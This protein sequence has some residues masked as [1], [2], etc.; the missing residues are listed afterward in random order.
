M[1]TP[2]LQALTDEN[3]E[4]LLIQTLQILEK[5]GLVCLPTET[6]YGIGGRSDMPEVEA[7]LREFKGERGEKPFSLHCADAD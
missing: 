6:V 1:T 3:R 2:M 5:G 4:D 7:R